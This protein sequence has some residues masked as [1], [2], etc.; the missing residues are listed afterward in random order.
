[1]RCPFC[2]AADSKVIDSRSNKDGFVVRRRR[3]C[4]ECKRRFTTY[5]KIEGF[6]PV[7]VKKDCRREPF[8]RQKIVR[9]VQQACQKRPVSIEDIEGIA[10]AMEKE[11]MERNEKEIPSREIGE[12]LMLRLRELDQVAY[13]RFASVYRESRDVEE[14][15]LELRELLSASKGVGSFSKGKEA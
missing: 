6:L 5:E 15:V 8:A 11:F 9:G 4:E 7:V 13:V 10:D 2:E 12:H 14:F 3:S 1:M